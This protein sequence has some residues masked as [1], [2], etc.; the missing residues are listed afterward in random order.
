MSEGNK[1]EDNILQKNIKKMGARLLKDDEIIL[2]LPT[3]PK[4]KEQ[5]EEMRRNAVLLESN[6]YNAELEQVTNNIGILGARGTGKSSVLKTLR[7]YLASQNQ[8]KNIKNM[9]LPLIIPENMSECMNLMS[10]ILGLFKEEVDRIVNIKEKKSIQCWEDKPF[11]IEICYNE[12]IKK[13]CFIQNEFRNI[14]VQSYTTENDYVKKSKEIFNSDID[15]LPK[16][17]EFINLLLKDSIYT[18]DCMIFVCIDDI[19]LSTH[20][21][22]D[23]VKTLLTY[24]SHPRIITFISGDLDTF[25]EALTLDFLRSERAL[26]NDLLEREFLQESKV[27][28]LLERKKLLAY[29]YLKKIVPPIYR[30]TVKNWS[31][32]DRGNFIIISEDK[33][34]KDFSLSQLLTD[35]FK[36]YGCESYFQY[37]DFIDVDIIEDN[38][39]QKREIPK[40]KNIPQVFHIFDDTSRGLTN[41][42]NLLFEIKDI[43]NVEITNENKQGIFQSVKLFLETVVASNKILSNHRNLIFNNVIQFG[44]DF[45]TTVVRC[46]NLF[47]STYKNSVHGKNGAESYSI[48]SPIDRFSLFVF[49][50]FSLRLLNQ[51][52]LMNSN[53]YIDLKKFALSDLI[54]YPEIS[55]STEK[56]KEFDFK[57]LEYKYNFK[58]YNYINLFFKQP[59]EYSIKCFQYIKN[60]YIDFNKV[61]NEIDEKNESYND[62]LEYEYYSLFT[63]NNTNEKQNVIRELGYLWDNLGD[64]YYNLISNISSDSVNNIIK[65]LLPINDLIEE[66]NKISAE[67]Y[68]EKYY[69]NFI[70]I[71][72]SKKKEE[73]YNKQQKYIQGLQ[74]VQKELQDASR[75]VYL[76]VN[77]FYNFIINKYKDKIFENN[78]LKS[79]E[80]YNFNTLFE[81]NNAKRLDYIKYIDMNNLWNSDYFGKVHTFIK[82]QIRNELGRCYKIEF[83]IPTKDFMESYKNFCDEYKGIESKAKTAYVKMESILK[84]TEQS[85][86]LDYINFE[87]YF[88]L[89]DEIFKLASNARIR[90]C[91]ITSKEL[92][93]AIQKM[94]LTFDEKQSRENIEN[95]ESSKLGT[96]LYLYCLYRAS[97]LNLETLYKQSESIAEFSEII[98]DIPKYV[99]EKNDEIEVE[100]MKNNNLDIEEMEELFSVEKE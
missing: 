2:I 47:N 32:S 6:K 64:Y 27:S 94:Y 75:K 56:I 82:E 20:R 28:K 71:I 5:I 91:K 17:N 45:E 83:S 84:N 8:D 80:K 92:Y 37:H 78:K 95:M 96:F 34:K 49:I 74:K 23:V 24:I 59:F 9:V 29:E 40:H 67:S 70:N 66:K 98:K 12:L 90:Y 55:G 63:T 88:K 1:M 33:D 13:Y 7:N 38:N 52:E 14:I 81:E 16:L 79:I 35:T 99:A 53:E 50:D 68:F 25:E 97:E 51:K 62:L 36:N 22:I 85:K 60:K 30:H 73:E 100:N 21:C 42:Y 3:Y 46:D 61:V 93:N 41:V 11:E 43:I 69:Y 44:N 89:Y 58:R 10:S 76:L 87:Q 31:L 4:I 57:I 48:K 19:D 54:N 65:R 39:G 26:S 72:E 15:F 18:E 77:L 86:Y